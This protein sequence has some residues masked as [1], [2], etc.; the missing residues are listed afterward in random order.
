MP[1][2][3]DYD[4]GVPHSDNAIE[5]GEDKVHGAG[6]TTDE[7]EIGHA[8]KTAPLPDL[9]EVN[10]GTHSGAGAPGQQDGHG[11]DAP[12]TQGERKGMGSANDL[13][14]PG[15]HPI[16]APQESAIRR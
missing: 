13:G 6:K 7:A 16:D 5:A 2:G 3:A 1:R 12:R 9:S 4:D 10:D 14:K 8:K 15:S 11:H